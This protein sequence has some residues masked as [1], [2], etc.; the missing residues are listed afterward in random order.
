[1]EIE[2][3]IKDNP[4]LSGLTQKE[5]DQRILDGLINTSVDSKTPTVVRIIFRNAFNFINSLL[6]F[7]SIILLILGLPTD[8][9]STSILVILNV[10]VASFQEVRAKKRLDEIALLSTPKVNAIRDSKFVELLPS[11]IVLDDLIYLE[12]GDQLV[13][14]GK[15]L[16]SNLLE[17]DEALLTGESDHIFKEIGSEVLSG[18]FVVSG[19]GIYKVTKVGNGNFINKLSQKAK[20]FKLPETPLQ[21]KVKFVVRAVAIITFITAILV[22]KDALDSGKS[23]ETRVLYLAVII[24]TVPQGLIFSTTFSYALG[25]IRLLKKDALIQHANAIESMSNIDVL[26]LDKTGTLTTGELKL[27]EIIPIDISEEDLKYKLGIFSHSISLHTQTSFSL[28]SSI[29]GNSKE[30]CLEV[31]FSSTR[32]WSGLTFND[33]EIKGT[34]IFG[35][36][37]VLKSS[38]NTFEN[39]ANKIDELSNQ[40]FRVLVFC[41]SED[42]DILENKKLPANL[43]MIGIVTFSDELKQNIKEILKQFENAKVAI[44]IIS[45]DNPKTVYNLACK[46]GFDPESKYI[47]GEE[48]KSLKELRDIVENFSIFGRINPDQKEQLIKALQKNKHYVAMVGDGVNDLLSLKK[49]DIGISMMSGSSATR[50]ISDIVLVNNMFDV[51]P[52]VFIEGQKISSALNQI[53]KVL[54]SRTFLVLFLV[55]TTYLLNLEFPV[56]PRQDALLSILTVGA[57]TIFLALWAKPLN[58]KNTLKNVFSHVLP[59]SLIVGTITLLIFALYSKNFAELDKAR[60]MLVTIA[61]LAGFTNLLIVNPLFFKENDKIKYNYRI[62]I[63]VTSLFAVFLGTMI[64]PKNL[65][66]LRLDKLDFVDYG[67]VLMSMI[68]INLA[69]FGFKNLMGKFNS[70]G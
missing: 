21:K 6:F 63:L 55:I 57:P 70:K 48:L 64:L 28:K 45:G 44:K 36:F 33:P 29:E 23:F 66:F 49:A 43:Q 25:I 59:F 14:D 69:L 40:G 17:L 68:T 56:L 26:C 35:A 30:V 8:A 5:V 52:R 2:S 58:S 16:F 11:E 46:A 67:I 7:I 34:F 37:D 53:M 12:P 4:N 24:A 20:G 32:K 42:I 50:N 13:V 31:P 15:I 9:L 10:I 47:S 18:S 19:S 3:L 62:I 51:L 27:S 65:N 41:F 22:Y 60:T 39:Y 38:I 1:M 54:L 61:T